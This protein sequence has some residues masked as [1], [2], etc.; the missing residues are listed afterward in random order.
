MHLASTNQR[1]PLIKQSALACFNVT[2]KYH[3]LFSPLILASTILD[4]SYP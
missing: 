2:Y 4:K 1:A 3:D